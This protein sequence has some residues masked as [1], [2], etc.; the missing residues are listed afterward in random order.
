M[1]DL[2]NI[3]V[4][5]LSESDLAYWVARANLHGTAQERNVLH[6]H[7]SYCPTFDPRLIDSMRTFVARK[8]GPVLP[9]RQFWH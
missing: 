4:S 1:E 5:E 9:A 8:L 7:Y 6:A 2:K 3:F